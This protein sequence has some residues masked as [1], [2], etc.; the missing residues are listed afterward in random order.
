M[1]QKHYYFKTLILLFVVAFIGSSCEQN[2]RKR[3][4]EEIV[5]PSSLDGQIGARTD[6]HAFMNMPEGMQ[7]PAGQDIQEEQNILNK[8]VAKPL[9]SWET[10]Q[11][12]E[13][14][15]GSNMRMVTFNAQKE[16]GAIDCFIIS[17]SG[18]AGGVEANVIR[19]MNQ[20]N[21]AIPSDGQL[22]DFLSRQ[23][24]ITAKG[25]FSMMVVDLTELPQA[26]LGARKTMKPSKEG[27]LPSMIA[28][29]AEIKNMV[30]FV[31][32]TGSKEAVLQ[33]REQFEFLC[34]SLTMKE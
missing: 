19:W 32:M 23:K 15:K 8:S 29:I 4:Y 3:E 28:A 18:Q 10:P 9:L 34:R 22:K 20:I 33:N 6:P 2:N 31:K 5:I 13:E 7:L 12:W 21:V 1:Y 11:G 27:Q 24:V 17:L 30:I 14:K 25:G 26:E 16:S